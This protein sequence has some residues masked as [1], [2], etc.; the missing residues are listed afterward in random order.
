LSNGDEPFLIVRVLVIEED[1]PQGVIK[2]SDRFFE[3]DFVLAKVVGRFAWVVL[4][5]EHALYLCG[6]G[7]DSMIV[8]SDFRLPTML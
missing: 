5:G 3:T 8:G 1:R 6:L 4:E 7:L 2:N